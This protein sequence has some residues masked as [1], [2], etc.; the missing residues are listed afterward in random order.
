MARIRG[1]LHN[2]VVVGL[3]EAQD[4]RQALAAKIVS[5]AEPAGTSTGVRVCLC[6]LSEQAG[7]RHHNPRASFGSHPLQKKRSEL[8]VARIHKTVARMSGSRVC[9]VIPFEIK[10]R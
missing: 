5:V 9:A 8:H 3:I 10:N 7:T 1:A 4:E 6:G 2:C